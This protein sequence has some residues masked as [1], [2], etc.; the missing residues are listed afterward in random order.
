[1]TFQKILVLLSISI[2]VAGTAH[3]D[4]GEG[5]LDDVS[6]AGHNHE[7]PCDAHDVDHQIPEQVTS[8]HWSY[9]K[10][11]ELAQKYSVEKKLPEGKP[12]SRSDLAECFLAVMVKIVE[13][14]EKEDPQA[15]RRDELESIAPLHAA[16]EN[17]LAKLDGYRLRKKAIEE[18]LVLI[19]PETPEFEYKA[20]V[21]GFL[22]SDVVRNFRL[23]DSSF[24]PDRNEGR[25]LHRMKPYVYWHPTDYLDIHIEGQGYGFTGGDQY[26][27][28]IS[29]Y[30]GFVEAR[31]PGK[32]WFALKGGRQEFNYGSAFVLGTDS[33]YNGLTFDAGRLRIKP[34]NTVTIDLLGGS[35]AAPFADG[36]KGNLLGAYV[37]YAPS[38]GNSIEAY[39]IRDTG[40][41]EHHTGE[42]LDTW[43]LRSTSKLGP[44]TLEVEPV[45]QSGKV[46]NSA[47]GANE[48][49]SAYGG[50][51]DL[52]GAFELGGHKN[53]I[54]V[55]Y[56][57]GSGDKNAANGLGSRKEFHNPNNDTSLMGDMG[58]V[59]DLSG[60]NVGN[61]HA[62]GIQIYTLGWGIDL[63]DSLN[64][65]ATGRKFTANAVEDGF[66]RRLGV[67]TDFTLTWNINKDFSAVI[68]YDH[69]F[70]NK[71]FHDASGSSKDIDYGYAMLVFNF[72][73][74]KLKLHKKEITGS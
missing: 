46:F 19:E 59:G 54:F 72:D 35:Y 53:T 7:E 20:G 28:K 21:N 3:A 44:L 37:T 45:Y 67:E 73:K 15:I 66:S 31:L 24:T 68:G 34:L 39:M 6:H 9:R 23:P 18:I 10:I 50:H 43:G 5:K 33:F 65:S 26:T 49:I 38:E 69:F 14:H 29:L 55:S 52:T 25:F 56:A 12:C 42:H 57:I 13:R 16:L 4:E 27:G 11:T 61:H 36:I 22:R 2:M 63:T 30:Q 41:T 47:T 8:E 62:S 1:M 64:F 70:T 48:D 32:E 51:M 58:V 71:F 74:T 40:S 17:E 60:I